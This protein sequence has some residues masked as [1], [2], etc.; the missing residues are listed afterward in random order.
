M[1]SPPRF[2]LLVFDWDGTL[3]DSAA[4]IAACVAESFRDLGLDPP[5][6]EDIRSTIGLGLDD[7]L[8]RLAPGSSVAVLTG[9]HR[10]S[11]LMSCDPLDC[12]ENVA[13]LPGWL[14]QVV[15]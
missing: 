6:D 9:A 14:G 13:E 3:M 1:A 15:A 2:R 7:V 5:P 11:Q 12:L 8:D 4:T 10:R